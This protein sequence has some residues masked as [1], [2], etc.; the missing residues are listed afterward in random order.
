MPRL[1]DDTR[2][3]LDELITLEEMQAAVNALRSLK[4]PG[5]DDLSAEFYKAFSAMLCPILLEIFHAAH[6]RQLLPPSFLQSHTV[7]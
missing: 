4:T 5:P 7:C 2:R 6:Q 1:D 3:M